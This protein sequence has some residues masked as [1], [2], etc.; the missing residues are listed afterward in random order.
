MPAAAPTSLVTDLS[1]RTTAAPSVAANAS[2]TFVAMEGKT[3]YRPGSN[4]L[5]VMWPLVLLAAA[6]FFT[7]WSPLAWLT[8]IG[9]LTVA[10]AATYEALQLRPQLA[11]LRVRRLLP[12]VAGRGLDF[13]VTWELEADA[14]FPVHGELRDVLPNDAV[15]R[16]AIRSFTLTPKNRRTTVTER[17]KIARRGRH[18]FG[19]LWVRLIG[20]R[21][22]IEMQ[23][24]CPSTASIRIMP[25]KFISRE[26]VLK[27]E[28]AAP[29]LLDVKARSRQHGVGTEFESLVEYREG[30]DPRRI[31]WRA[32]ARRRRPVVRRFQI[33]RHRDVMILIDCGRLMGSDALRGTKLDCAVDAGLI[34]A[35]TALAG[36]DRCGL[37][38]FDNELRGYLPPVAGA[39]A[40]QSLAVAVFDVRS[41][42]RETDF[43]PVFAA[44]QTRQAK[45]SLIVVLSDVADAETSAQFQASLAGLSRRHVVLLA[46]LRTPAIE[47]I[48]RAPL[49]SLLDGAEKA[50]AFRLERE[51]RQTMQVLRKAGVFVLD[52]EPAQLTVPLVNRFL[53]LRSRNLL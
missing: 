39:A 40:V 47:Q 51:R 22:L 52:V 31:D 24:A 3:L 15:P 49:N 19:P 35:R 12:V 41:E 26:E 29:L 42:F 48:I 13:A 23:R 1:D 17:F 38:L 34:L 36:G 18:S 32:T 53:D 6:Y 2:T 11:S 9:V 50:V 7:Q 4:A 5:L 43:G 21:G 10:G 45:R 44:L 33:E 27:D 16:L 37:V 25:E 14:S 28:G 20:P 8:A 46:A 30:D